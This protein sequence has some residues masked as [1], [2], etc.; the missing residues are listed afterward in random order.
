M[1]NTVNAAFRF[2][3]WWKQGLLNPLPN[4]RSVKTVLSVL[5]DV[6]CDA[7]GQALTAS[8]I[9][10]CKKGA[11]I[12]LLAPT[13]QV[14]SR[15]ISDAQHGL[16]LSDI[17]EEVL[18]F[19]ASE[20]IV[21]LSVDQEYIYSIVKSEL[22]DQLSVLTSN[23]LIC[24]GI[25]FDVVGPFVFA[26]QRGDS[27]GSNKRAQITLLATIVLMFSGLVVGS[28]YVPHSEGQKRQGLSQQLKQLTL[29]TAGMNLGNG[30][31]GSVVAQIELRGAER[32]ALALTSVSGALTEAT[33]VDQLIL[34]GNELLLDASAESATQVQANL[35][36]SGAFK[37]TEFV[38]TISRSPGQEYERFRLKAIIMEVR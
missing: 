36:A 20:L 16:P 1:S 11:D 27:R 22:S 33:I 3:A 18:P 38:T 4:A 21:T 24:C 8:E 2:F 19:D 9:D 6:L 32:V 31:A 26:Q 34:S 37:S 13:E 35:E 10:Y 14:M 30:Q 25:A 7:T 5:D 29:E 15:R 23:D 28:L 12:Y 17:A